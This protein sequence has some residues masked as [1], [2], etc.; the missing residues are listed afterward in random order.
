MA[1]R[2][3]PEEPLLFVQSAA[4]RISSTGAKSAALRAQENRK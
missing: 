4:A 1:L 3:Y 2:L